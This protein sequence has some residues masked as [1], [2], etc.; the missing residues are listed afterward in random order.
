MSDKTA[1]PDRVFVARGIS[2]LVRVEP[3][4]LTAIDGHNSEPANPEFFTPYYQSTYNPDDVRA[5]IEAGRQ[6]LDSKSP[7]REIAK[8]QFE[9]LATRLQGDG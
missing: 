6:A 8:A 3:E 7:F 9:E 1:M 4:L 5:L 2:G